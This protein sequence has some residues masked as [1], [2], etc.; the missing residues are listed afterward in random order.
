MESG[1][2]DEVEGNAHR[3][4][5][6]IHCE[7]RA[8]GIA[9]PIRIHSRSLDT[10]GGGHLDIRKIRGETEPMRDRDTGRGSSDRSRALGVADKSDRITSNGDVLGT[11]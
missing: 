4:G 11:E 8:R 1:S 9:D 2:P 7:L 5:V 10:A 6:S 3:G